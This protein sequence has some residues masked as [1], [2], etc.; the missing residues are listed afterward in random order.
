MMWD[1]QRM[2]LHDWHPREIPESLLKGA[3]PQEQQGHTLPPLEQW[4]L[5]VLHEGQIPGAL[6]KR[7][8]TAYTHRLLADARERVPRLR[9]DLSDVG[10]R[11][12]LIDPGRIGVICTKYRNSVGNGWSFPPLSECREAWERLYGPQRW[13]N[14]IHEMAGMVVPS[15]QCGGCEANVEGLISNPF[16]PPHPPYPP[17]SPLSTKDK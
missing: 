12:F 3:A 4:Y 10:L 5:M 14:Q 6:P 16:T 11:N 13:D 15:G 7:P 8:S 9:W 17:H 2:D 1:L